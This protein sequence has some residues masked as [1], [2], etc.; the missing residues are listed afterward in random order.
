MSFHSYGF[1]PK[2]QYPR[3]K[4]LAERREAY[5]RIEELVHVELAVLVMDSQNALELLTSALI[6]CSR[7]LADAAALHQ[8]ETVKLVRPRDHY[9]YHGEATPAL[10]LFSRHV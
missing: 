8:Q 10:A 5:V 2:A 9:T 6:L 7:A 1:D 4:T 3:A